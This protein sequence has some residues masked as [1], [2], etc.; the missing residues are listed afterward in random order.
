MSNILHNIKIAIHGKLRP[1]GRSF[2]STSFT[3]YCIHM[4][5]VVG[6]GNPGDEYA[7][8]RHNAG[9]LVL[10]ALAAKH[11]FSAWKK[12]GKSK[13]LL[14]AGEI[15]G[16]RMQ[17]VCPDNFMNNSGT[18]VAYYIKEKEQLSDLVVVYD[19]MDIALGRI[20]V[21]FDRGTG[22]HNGIE[23]IQQHV[24]S[25][26]FVRVRLGVSP[27]SEEGMQKPKG[28]QAVLDFLLKNFRKSELEELEKISVRVG[29]A[30]TTY[31]KEGKEK[32][33]N[34]FNT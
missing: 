2:L 16:V 19:D 5:T 7:K 26:E 6:L 33:M 14:S 9:R 1:C 15:D 34:V 27:V 13:A 22:G 17:F 30:L 4:L 23:S 28:E 21:S 32:T 3:L 8:T 11:D 24:Q 20:K 29:E 18:S 10:E 31:A 25:R 12:D